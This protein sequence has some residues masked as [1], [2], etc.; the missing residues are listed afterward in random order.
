MYSLTKEYVM[1]K[2]DK[3]HYVLLALLLALITFNMLYYGAKKQN[4]NVDE[5]YS[6]GLA[7][8]EYLPF[9]HFG[10]SDYDVKDWMLEYGFGESLGDMF[11]N[12]VKDFKILQ[13]CDFHFKD[14]IIYRDY[15][16]AQA[17]SADTRTTTWVPGQ[18][19]ADYL[20]VGESNTFNYASVYYNQRGDVHPPFYYIL[21]HT[22]CSVFQGKFSK[23]FGISINIAA[24]LLA[25]L[26]LY[27]MVER[28]FGGKATALAVVAVYGLSLGFV[29]STL[30]IR[31]YALFTLM[32]VSFCYVHLKIAAED[33]QIKGKNRCLLILTTLLGFLT[34]YYFVLYAVVFV[35][36]YVVWM[37]YRK[38]W[39]ALLSYVLTLAGTAV[40]GLVIWPFAIRHVF[41]GYRG[42]AAL[43]TI[44]SGDYSMFLVKLLW[45]QIKAQLAGGFGWLWLV[46]AVLALWGCFGAE[47][48]KPSVWKILLAVIPTIAYTIMVAQISPFVADRYVMCV[49]P[50]WCLFLVGGASLA[51]RKSLNGN[52]GKYFEVGIAVT[53]A[54]LVLV[55]NCYLK[56]PE[57]FAYPGYGIMEVPEN[58]DCV[59]VLSDGDWNESAE[60]SI[61]LSKCRNVA[62]VY[63][64]DLEVLREGYRYEPGGKLLVVVRMGLDPDVILQQTK[65]ALGVEMLAE[66]K[67]DSKINST[68][69]WLE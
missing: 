11:R 3:M 42:Q 17:N 58:T 16:I 4:F 6:Y 9:M 30:L 7:N 61:M 48:R 39:R 51:L 13:E 65:E 45:N 53:A 21:L 66:S 69:I 62:I 1:D 29:L 43:D 12:L 54:V 20:R 31:M 35:A 47:V 25:L 10:V 63:Q 59:Y 57:Q 27:R 34:H 67:R 40:L 15:L 8:S 32:T 52:K 26:V 28:Y 50:F 23:W 38:E 64:S 36:I 33:F 19:Y 60:E 56:M 55:N 2:R 68:H 18:D 41:N 14:S 49:Y 46:A 5:V 44:A 22:I 37:T 24:L